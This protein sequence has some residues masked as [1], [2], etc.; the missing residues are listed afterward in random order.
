MVSRVYQ[1]R[2]YARLVGLV[3]VIF[4]AAALAI[5][6]LARH[7]PLN[8]DDGQIDPLWYTSPYI[9]D[10]QGDVSNT[11]F[12]IVGAWIE[13]DDDPPS[14]FNFRIKLATLIPVD[15]LVTARLDCNNDGDFTDLQDKIVDY[16]S[17][18]NEVIVSDG[19]EENGA[20]D[21][22][23][24]TFGEWIAPVDY[25]WKAEVITGVADTPD[26]TDCLSAPIKVKFET[27]QVYDSGPETIDSTDVREYNAPAAV[28]LVNLQARST[29]LPHFIIFLLLVVC[30]GMMILGWSRWIPPHNNPRE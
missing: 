13:V 26:W 1:F 29:G 4:L 3:M 27:R 16:D 30:M 6:A 19:D 21:T 11:A 25:E 5:P 8:T 14:E 28:R 15:G 20:W 7:F 24:E 23:E 10:P 17:N 22:F 2:Q 12:D 18:F 9:S